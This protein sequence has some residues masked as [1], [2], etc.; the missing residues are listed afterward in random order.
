M[1]R[2]AGLHY[3]KEYI[4]VNDLVD[5]DEGGVMGVDFIEMGLNIGISV[6]G[7]EEWRIAVFFNHRELIWKSKVSGI[8]MIR[9]YTAFGRKLWFL[10]VAH[11]LRTL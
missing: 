10:E 8:T 1:L 4:P 3:R 9:N 2:T 7:I 6:F 5:F 11:N